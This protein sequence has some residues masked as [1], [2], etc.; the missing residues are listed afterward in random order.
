MQHLI[1]K[2]GCKAS[3]LQCQLL[4]SKASGPVKECKN[5][6]RI[7]P[8]FCFKLASFCFQ[9]VT[10]RHL[11]FFFR[12]KTFFGRV[13]QQ[14]W[15]TSKHVVCPSKMTLRFANFNTW[16]ALISNFAFGF[17]QTVKDK[18]RKWK[19]IVGVNLTTA[20][21]DPDLQDRRVKRTTSDRRC[22]TKT[23]VAP[24]PTKWQGSWT[25]LAKGIAL[26]LIKVTEN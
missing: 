12:S 2:W 22:S 25:N 3:E 11:S 24:A 21:A 5:L 26:K 16:F 9:V 18:K 6:Y 8:R 4:T 19:V 7:G 23:V 17:R 10:L 1:E 15:R 13:T 20:M 14:F